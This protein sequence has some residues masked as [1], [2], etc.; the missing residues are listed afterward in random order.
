MSSSAR[1]I[2]LRALCL[3][4]AGGFRS[5][6]PLGALSLTHEEAPAE[7][8]WRRWPVLGSAWGRTA[9]IVLAATEFITDK[10]PR[11]QSRLDLRAQPS[12]IDTGLLGRVAAVGL[13]G[14]ML[15]SERRE[16]GSTATGAIFAAIGALVGNF[17]GYHARRS[18]VEATGLPDTLVAVVEDVLTIALITAAVPDRAPR[19]GATGLLSS[20][21]TRP[22]R[23]GMTD[24]VLGL[25]R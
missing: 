17:G 18:A 23:A 5:W 6:V 21:P 10:L 2:A 13:A 4:V 8:G 7:H 12:T 9:L 16:P 25:F 22:R 11:T 24:A 14:A 1:S 15:G 19:S 20:A 3:G